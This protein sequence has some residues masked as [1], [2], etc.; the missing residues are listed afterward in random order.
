MPT[1]AN[2]ATWKAAKKSKVPYRN[3][4]AYLRHTLQSV[5]LTEK[6]FYFQILLQQTHPA[7]DQRETIH[8]QVQ[9]Q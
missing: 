6:T 1:D 2:H 3:S 8:L 5:V 7:Q 9:L 4:K